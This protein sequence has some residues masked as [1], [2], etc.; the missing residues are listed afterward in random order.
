MSL[1]HFV[2][3]GIH[4]RSRKRDSTVK[5]LQKFHLL[6]LRELNLVAL[7]VIAAHQNLI[8]NVFRGLLLKIVKKGV[9]HCAPL[10]LFAG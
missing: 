1:E 10:K 9:A 3:Y 4:L 5:L 2:L 6:Q 8:P 7:F